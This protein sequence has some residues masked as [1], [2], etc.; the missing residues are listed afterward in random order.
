MKYTAVIQGDRV[1]IELNFAAG[2]VVEARIGNQS[3]RLQA[4]EVEPG[5]YWFVSDDKSIEIAVTEG[6]AGYSVSI[7]MHNIP[8]E[9]LD[10]RAALRLAAHHGDDGAVEIRAPMPGKIVK[11]LAAEGASVEPN[12][13]LVV[14]EAM[15][16][17]NE[18]KTP[19]KGIVRRLMAAEGTAIN[20]GDLIAIV[21]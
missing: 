4:S 19:R 1:E 13:G 14:M 2:D 3:Y 18:I 20:A 15:K 6:V 5:I 8:V 10:A 12:Q 11:V 17:Q 7:G 9:I 16:M 21:E